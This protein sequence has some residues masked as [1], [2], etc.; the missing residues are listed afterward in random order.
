LEKKIPTNYGVS[1]D[2]FEKMGVKKSGGS[3]KALHIRPFP[4]KVRSRREW[5]RKPPPFPTFLMPNVPKS[6]IK[7]IG[8]PG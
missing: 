7:I 6:R 8:D 2:L 4:P 5:R 1:R 3:P